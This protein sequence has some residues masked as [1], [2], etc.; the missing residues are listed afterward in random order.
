[1]KGCP[2][3]SQYFI[4]WDCWRPAGIQPCLDFPC[5]GDAEGLTELLSSLVAA[6]GVGL[7]VSAR[8]DGAKSAPR[9]AGCCVLGVERACTSGLLCR[10]IR[11]AEGLSTSVLCNHTDGK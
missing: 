2:V 1:M 6:P 11:I 10:C 8:K 3:G 9:G 4:F 5:T 7:S